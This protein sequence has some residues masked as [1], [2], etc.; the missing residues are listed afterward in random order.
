MQTEHYVPILLC[1]LIPITGLFFGDAVFRNITSRLLVIFLSISNTVLIVRIVQ[2]EN[3]MLA[4]LFGLFAPWMTLRTITFFLIYNSPKEFLLTHVIRN[5]SFELQWRAFP[6]TRSL[7]RLLWAVDLVLDSRAIAWCYSAT[8]CTPCKH[9]KEKAS[10]QEKILNDR[11]GQVSNLAYVLT[12]R[13]LVGLVWIEICQTRIFPTIREASGHKDLLQS[14]LW[15]STAFRLLAVWTA[16]FALVDLVYT[17]SRLLSCFM[18]ILG[19]DSSLISITQP[20]P[21]GSPASLFE[22]GIGGKFFRAHIVPWLTLCSQDTGGDSG[23]TISN[24]ASRRQP[25]GFSSL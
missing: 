23:T 2:F 19:C 18:F 14:W 20:S 13:F 3:Q 16:S 7:A 12:I 25:D 21:W 6:A 22:H 10:K 9:H 15:H 17:G 1:P 4:F 11:Q 8:D 5:R 24:L